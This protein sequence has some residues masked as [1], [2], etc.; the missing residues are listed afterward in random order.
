LK[1]NLKRMKLLKCKSSINELIA[2]FK[3]NS[4]IVYDVFIVK[5]RNQTNN[6]LILIFKSNTRFERTSKGELTVF[7]FLRI[8]IVRTSLIFFKMLIPLPD[9]KI[10][11]FL[12]RTIFGRYHTLRKPNGYHK[13]MILAQ[14]WYEVHELIKTRGCVTL[15]PCHLH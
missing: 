1:G 15:W 14:H 6:Y 9:V 8:G 12:G 13:I 10:K 3:K 4:S 5:K 7:I 2:I 11:L